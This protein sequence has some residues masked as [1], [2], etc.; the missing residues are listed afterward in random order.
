[1][2]EIELD[3]GPDTLEALNPERVSLRLLL[4]ES[5]RYA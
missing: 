1:M 5:A 4:L 2:G 3:R